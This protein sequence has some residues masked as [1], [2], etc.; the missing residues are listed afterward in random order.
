MEAVAD[1]DVLDL[2][3]PTVDVQDEVVELLVVG[4]FIEPEVAV[5]LGGLHQLPDLAADRRQFGRVHGGDVAV[6][7]EELLQTGDVAVRLGTGHGR[8]EVIDDRGVRA[9][10]GLGALAGVVDEER[11]EER[12]VAEDGIGPALR[13]QRRVLAG[14]PL[15]G[16]VLAH[17]DHRVGTESAVG[18]GSLQPAIGGQVV[19]GR[20]EVGVVIDRHRVLAE[21]AGRL[22]HQHHVA[23]DQGG[24]HDLAGVVDEERARGLAP[25]RDHV[26]TQRLGRCA[27][28]RWY[29]SLLIRV[30]ASVSWPEVNHSSSWPPAA[31]IEWMRASPASVSSSRS[32]PGMAPGAPRS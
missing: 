25:S 32:R 28:Q 4:A 21:T 22:D 12:E 5:Q 13:R 2:A 29:C 6:F 23:R 18:A 15:Q 7:V 19:V 17:V 20:R 31:I 27:V 30:W 8:D 1:L 9:T 10:F 14:Q 16:A 3:E 24:E 26:V 11:V